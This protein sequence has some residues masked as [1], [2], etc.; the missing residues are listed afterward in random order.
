MEKL[1]EQTKRYNTEAVKDWLKTYPEKQQDIRNMQA[2]YERLE[3]KLSSIGSPTLS[4]MPKS[5]SRVMDKEAELIAQKVDLEKEIEM[6]KAD[7]HR[8]RL[9]IEKVMAC[10]KKA[11]EKAVI[12]ARYLCEENWDDISFILFGAKADFLDK[13][14]SYQRRTYMIH[15]SALINMAKYIED[16]K[17]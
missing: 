1:S 14:D 8:L 13:E 4:D 16:G 9:E 12:R 3:D 6:V 17:V 7:A 15:G 2:Q 10:L 5:P 11:N